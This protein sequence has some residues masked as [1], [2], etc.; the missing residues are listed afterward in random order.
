MRTL[1]ILLTQTNSEAIVEMFFLLFS[2][3]IIGYMTLQL[4]H[5]SFYQRLVKANELEIDQL[6]NHNINLYAEKSNLQE[7]LR[8]KRNEIARLIKEVNAHNAEIVHVR[9]VGK[10][11]EPFNKTKEGKEIFYYNKLGL[12]HKEQAI[13]LAQIKGIGLWVEEKHMFDICT[14]DQIKKLIP[15]DVESITMES[16]VT[17][18][19]Q[20]NLDTQVHKLAKKQL[21]H[22]IN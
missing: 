11:S 15:I 16:D 13:N 7:C 8:E 9:I 14:F 5:K 3:A 1:L 17:P 2:G 19:Y 20:V 10:K 12:A 22:T 6:K 18:N 4:Y 21:Y